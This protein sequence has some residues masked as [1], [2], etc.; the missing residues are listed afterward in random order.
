VGIGISF[1]WGLA[2]NSTGTGKLV[3]FLG[4]ALLTIAINYLQTGF[5]SGTP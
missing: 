5:F 3:F 4:M 2:K 1:F